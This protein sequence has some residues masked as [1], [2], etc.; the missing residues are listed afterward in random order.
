MMLSDNVTTW[1]RLITLATLCK[2]DGAEENVSFC[3]LRMCSS[4]EIPSVG[5][6][7]EEAYV[8]TVVLT[9]SRKRE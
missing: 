9:F 2:Q 6:R 5:R 3:I 7:A 1:C 4:G 8:K